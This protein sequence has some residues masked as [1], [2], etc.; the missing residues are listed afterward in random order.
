MTG[1]LPHLG[2][3]I[4]DQ[5]MGNI[6]KRHG[7]PPAPERKNMTTRKALI[8]THMGVLVAADCFITKIWS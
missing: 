7:M 3:T 1:A 6:L 4:S 2:D 5:T 8:Q